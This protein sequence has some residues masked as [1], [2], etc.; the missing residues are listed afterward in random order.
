MYADV[1][2]RCQV[3]H[4]CF[5]D[6]RNGNLLFVKE[7]CPGMLIDFRNERTHPVPNCI[8]IDPSLY[9][10]MQYTRWLIRS[11]I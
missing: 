1:E 8:S 9:L 6:R 3:W 4:Q 11:C 5:G 2:A 7:Q 10:H